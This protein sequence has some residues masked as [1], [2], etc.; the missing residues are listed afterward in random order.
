MKEREARGGKARDE[1]QYTRWGWAGKGCP[2]PEDRRGGAEAPRSM[3]AAPQLECGST[4][5][6]RLYSR[7]GAKLLRF[8]WLIWCLEGRRPPI[9]RTD[10]APPRCSR[11][12]GL[13][14][15][16]ALFRREGAGVP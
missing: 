9:T 12:G 1:S 15:K 4:I 3:N 11:R 8:L 6:V 5:G 2:L 7:L 13:G 10:T 14:E 16:P